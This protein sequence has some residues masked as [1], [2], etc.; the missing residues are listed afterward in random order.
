MLSEHSKVK[1]TNKV[2]SEELL[3]KL[4]EKLSLWCPITK[5]RDRRVLHIFRYTGFVHVPEGIIQMWRHRRK[6]V[7][8]DITFIEAD[9]S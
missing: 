7:V 2:T 8:R 5:R 9:F 4:R 6:I 3:E 1:C